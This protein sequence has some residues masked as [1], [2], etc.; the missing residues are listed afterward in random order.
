[1]TSDNIPPS[2]YHPRRIAAAEP[3]C[4]AAVMADSEE[5]L[6]YGALDAAA[7]RAANLFRSLG[8]KTGDTIAACLPNSLSVFVLYWGAQR[9]GLYYCPIAT[10]LGSEEIA[11]IVNDSDA[12]LLFT[13]GAIKAAA[14]FPGSV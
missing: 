2:M 6:T 4:V 5:T 13:D 3:D 14:H 11:Y 8:L 9:A 1:M 10:H 12:A 7:N